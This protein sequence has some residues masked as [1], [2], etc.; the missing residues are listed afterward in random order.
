MLHLAEKYGAI[1]EN[2]PQNWQIIQ[3]KNGVADISLSGY[4]VF[5][6]ENGMETV[7]IKVV[8]ENDGRVVVPYVKCEMLADRKWHVTIKNVPAGGLYRIESCLN[9]GNVGLEGSE[10]GDMI[11]HVGV[12]DL[13]V[14]AGQSNA[15][16][17]GRDYVYDSAEIGVHY[18]KSDGTWDLA[19]HPL[20]DATNTIHPINR[21]RVNAAHSPYLLFGKILKNNVGYPIG[22]IP[23]ALGSTALSQWNPGESG[24]LYD[25]M[26]NIIQMVGG[27]VTAI[28][29][30]QGCDDTTEHK[31]ETYSE[32]FENMVRHARCDLKADTLPFFTVQ[33]NKSIVKREVD[34]C[35]W[36][37]MREIQRMAARQIPY[38]YV[39]PSMDVNV[40]DRIHNNA[41]G[42]MVIGARLANQALK[43]I[44]GKNTLCDAPEIMSA[45]K[46]SEF[47]I[48][49]SFSNV[50]GTLYFR[51]NLESEIPFTV[52]MEGRENHVI[53][54]IAEGNTIILTTE[55]PVLEGSLVSCGALIY[56]SSNLPYDGTSFLPILAF[57]RHQI[58]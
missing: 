23:T 10:V 6:E 17:Y 33:L 48:E 58:A 45:V 29:W 21:P 35:G 20:G 44:Y 32:R 54:C 47:E 41:S 28:L 30:Y 24:E 13:Y 39:V 27:N 42:N 1:I 7:Y 15:V 56:T 4:W 19:S 55:N 12:G 57:Y 11:K 38:V 37:H 8:D 5:Q 43:Y 22:L 25:N 14:I 40:C 18:F 53:D 3:Q 34:I 46:Q 50:Y 31:W 36:G 2:G 52:E 16:G 49:L 26:M 9:R 51:R